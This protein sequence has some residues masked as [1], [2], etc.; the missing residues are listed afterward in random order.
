[1]QHLGKRWVVA[2]TL[3]G[4]VGSVL[5]I[6]SAFLTAGLGVGLL[7]GAAIGTAQWWVLRTYMETDTGIPR[8]SRASNWVVPSLLGGILPGWLVLFAVVLAGSNGG[9][10]VRDPVAYVLGVSGSAALF[11]GVPGALAGLLVGVWHWRV[12][13]R[14]LGRRDHRGLLPWV[15]A[16]T[17]GWAGSW[18]LAGA[19]GGLAITAGAVPSGLGW[20]LLGSGLVGFASCW[21]LLGVLTGRRLSRLV[22][23]SGDDHVPTPD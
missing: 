10:P 13:Q 1:M 23:A 20:L 2:T 14:I 8:A 4:V 12:L 16:T 22:H 18:A 3:G 7:V 5:G 11:G 6:A 15:A 17:L 21:A 19:A 9:L